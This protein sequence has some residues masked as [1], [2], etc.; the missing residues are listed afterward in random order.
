MFI[1]E[2]SMAQSNSTRFRKPELSTIERGHQMDGCPLRARLSAHPEISPE[3]NSLCR[4]YESSSD[5]TI[6][7]GP[8]CVYACK[9]I[10]HAR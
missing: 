5:E 8:P 7:R 10:I 2:E 3:S 4:L 9:E 6:N 1:K